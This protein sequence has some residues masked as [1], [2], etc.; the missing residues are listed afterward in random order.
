MEPASAAVCICRLCDHSKPTSTASA[1]NP[2]MIT[3]AMDASTMTCPDS[4][5]GLLM[6]SDLPDGSTHF[7]HISR[8]TISGLPILSTLDVEGKIGPDQSDCDVPLPTRFAK[9]NKLQHKLR[10]RIVHSSSVLFI[11]RISESRAV[12]Q[13]PVATARISSMLWHNMP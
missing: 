5:F 6:T 9:R 13:R 7:R 2:M 3:S 1:A 11:T 4:D 10:H 12:M 8:A